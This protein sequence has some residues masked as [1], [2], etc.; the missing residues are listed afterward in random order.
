MQLFVCVLGLLVALYFPP[1][2]AFSLRPLSSCGRSS[3]R[4][5][6]RAIGAPRQPAVGTSL[7]VANLDRPDPPAAA[8][9]WAGVGIA[10]TF[11]LSIVSLGMQASQGQTLASQGQTL[12]SQGQMLA[13][14]SQTQV[15]Q[16][17]LLATLSQTQ[18]TQGVKFDQVTYF[19]VGV[20]ALAAFGS[21]VVNV[22]RYTDELGKTK[23]KDEG[24]G[25]KGE[26]G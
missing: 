9:S 10:G 21:S 17:Q 5:T 22:L 1:T 20:V 24:K 23:M 18:V 3:C 7:A 26:G 6:P 4:P 14:L 16:G 2:S 25:G 19:V 8:F 15:T 12:A 11:C 13:S